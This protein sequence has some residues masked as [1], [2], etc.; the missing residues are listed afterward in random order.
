MA[1]THV[2][3]RPDEVSGARVRAAL[4][5]IYAPS[6]PGLRA[7]IPF[8]GDVL[9]IGRHAD[10][11]ISLRDDAAASRNHARLERRGDTVYVA[12]LGSTNGTWVEG[13]RISGERVLEP[14]DVLRV[15]NTLFRLATDDIDLLIHHDENATRRPSRLV[16]GAHIRAIAM[17]LA[18]LARSKGSLLIIGEGG[19]GKELAARELHELSGRQGRF[20]SV[21]CSGFARSRIEAGLFGGREPG[22]EQNAALEQARGGTL[23][24]DEV[25]ELPLE[26]QAKLVHALRERPELRVVAATRSNLERSVVR[27]TFRAD[28]LEL[29]G[30]QRLVLP[31]LRERREDLVPL[32][33]DTLI[34]LGRSELALSVE[35]VDAL[36]RYNFPGNV[37]E[38]AELV[39]R[40]ASAARGATLLAMHL[41]RG[42]SRSSFPNEDREVAPEPTAT[43]RMPKKALLPSH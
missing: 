29:L 9:R 40:A 2:P 36:A 21:P 34:S 3:K 6:A 27:E 4:C 26:T 1:P 39:K 42:L 38:L 31:P 20:V 15:G 19:T 11:E 18:R 32:V 28:L 22:A 5:V 33:E 16:G 17:S 12:D 24:L 14:H 8:Q 23:F 43:V 37:R 10:N 30:Q 7:S 35:F 13:E 41:P 25:G